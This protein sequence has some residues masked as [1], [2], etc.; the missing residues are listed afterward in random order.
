[1]SSNTRV[2]A[3]FSRPIRDIA[4]FRARCVTMTSEVECWL[5]AVQM[6]VRLNDRLTIG[7]EIAD[8]RAEGKVLVCD[9]LCFLRDGSRSTVIT[10][11][12]RK[13]LR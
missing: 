3:N 7:F 10:H 13:G 6:P 2:V 5:R 8:F 1:M 12:G 9:R 11:G 4:G